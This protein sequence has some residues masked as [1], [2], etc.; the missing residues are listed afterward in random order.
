M[1]DVV[2]TGTLRMLRSNMDLDLEGSGELVG[3]G[4]PRPVEFLISC[5]DVLDWGEGEDIPQWSFRV[6]SSSTPVA[7]VETLLQLDVPLEPA[8][9]RDLEAFE[10]AASGN[11]TAR[12][13]IDALGLRSPIAH[14][15]LAG[16][17][18]G[19]FLL[20]ESGDELRLAFDT[21]SWWGRTALP[22]LLPLMQEVDFVAVDDQAVLR[23]TDYVLPT[24]GDPLDV[25][26]AVELLLAS[27]SDQIVYELRPEILEELKT[28]PSPQ[29][30]AGPILLRLE[31]GLVVFEEFLIPSP[32]G[33]LLID[34]TYDL[35]GEGTR[36]IVQVPEKA[37]S[38]TLEV[39][40]VNGAFE[41]TSWSVD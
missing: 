34:G 33:D 13:R 21:E 31:E 38:R 6:T 22:G 30:L 10:L 25:S 8:F 5:P 40:N 1:A 12:C 4:D 20:A 16:V 2:L 14:L 26:A 3:R 37:G 27:E 35:H 15:T 11:G 32:S 39:K 29:H 17:C 19:D 18:T 41:L 9:G 24:D 36:L 23:L 7:D 28:R